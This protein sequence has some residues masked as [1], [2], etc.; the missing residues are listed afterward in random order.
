MINVH[1]K[2][3]DVEMTQIIIKTHHV[4]I[5]DSIK[6]YIDKKLSKLDHFFDRIQE[7]QVDLDIETVPNEEDRQIASA[8]VYVPGTALIARDSSKDLYA[9]VDGMIEKLQRQLKKYKDKLRMKHRHEAMKTKRL[10]RRI[11]VPETVETSSQ[12]VSQ[13]Q[14][15]VPKPMYIEDAA[16]I[17]E[18][19]HQPFLVFQNAENEKINVI[20]VTDD[21]DFGVIEP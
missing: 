17:L 7:I 11:D 3:K 2:S 18:E 19:G 16:I 21:G 14:L 1:N 6:E 15:Y 12:S 9:S 4:D 5:T 10:I 8:T 13:D 20:Y